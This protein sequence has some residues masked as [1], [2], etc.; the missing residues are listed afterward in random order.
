LEIR[1]DCKY[2][3]FRISKKTRE[4]EK[5]PTNDWK[6][7][8]SFLFVIK[9]WLSIPFMVWSCHS[10]FDK[11]R[12][13]ENTMTDENNRISDKRLRRRLLVISV[14]STAS[15]LTGILSSAYA[16]QTG[17]T[18]TDPHDPPGQGRGRNPNRAGISDSDPHDPPG[19]GRGTRN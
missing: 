6:P 19:Q 8:F 16:Q 14:G 13:K 7:V 3:Q 18:D 10:I 2:D 15:V 9:L 1:N 12:S 17:M 5:F 4:L 11:P